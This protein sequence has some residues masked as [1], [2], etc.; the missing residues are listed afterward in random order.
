M[1]EREIRHF[2][3][4]ADNSQDLGRPAIRW[5]TGYF[6]AIS[7]GSKS[8]APGSIAELRDFFQGKGAYIANLTLYIRADGKDGNT[9]L[10]AS[11]ALR[12]GA[13]AVELL[14]TTYYGVIGYCQINIG[15]M[16]DTSEWSPYN[17][18]SYIDTLVITGAGRASNVIPGGAWMSRGVNKRRIRQLS[19]INF[20]FTRTWE[21]SNYSIGAYSSQL[22]ILQGL[23]LD[24]SNVTTAAIGISASIGS[25]S[26][27]G[28][29][30][31]S[32]KFSYIFDF[33]TGLAGSRHEMIS[34]G[35]MTLEANSE[36]NSI[37]RIIG[38]AVVI[39]RQAA[40]EYF[41]EYNNG[42]T[43]VAYFSRQSYGG[44]IIFNSAAAK[45]AWQNG[46]NSVITASTELG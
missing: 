34:T 1:S 23:H 42:A 37:I 18:N 17:I 20:R 26:I 4:A 21:S 19:L 29:I 14:N 6:S 46:W 9:G 30:T 5:K 2:S 7:D 16:D 25:L 8:I 39:L 35:K 13:R 28:D 44:K 3:P 40:A 32:G 38:N 11:S 27:D 41:P 43:T 33:G 31:F 24:H 45:T 22:T 36:A 12:T 10:T 15:E